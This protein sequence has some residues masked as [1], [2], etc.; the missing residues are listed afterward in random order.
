MLLDFFFLFLC[1]LFCL[2]II[3]NFVFFLLK[4]DVMVEKIGYVFFIFNNIVLDKIYDVV[5]CEIKI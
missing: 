3:I 5:C 1:N 4:V 2:I